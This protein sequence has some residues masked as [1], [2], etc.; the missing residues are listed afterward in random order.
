MTTA[1][2]HYRVIRTELT[3]LA[4]TLSAEQAATAVPALPGWSVHDTYAHVAG[5]CHDIVAGTVG[6]VNNTEWTA[7]HVAAGR[8]RTLAEICEQWSAEGPQAEA[9]LDDPAG[10]GN[11]RAVFDVFH[12]AHDIRGAL[13]RVEARQ[14][15]EAAFVAT[16]MTKFF[17]SGWGP[18]G[19]PAIRLST[20]S[21]SWHLGAEDAQ[22]VAALDTSDFE[23]ARM[24]IGRRSRAQMLAAGWEGD[25]EPVVDH[26]TVFGP[27]V[28][29]LTE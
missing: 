8:G 10:R 18:S 5:V 19:L 15:P 6:D 22:P 28:T 21:G 27:P 12:H 2:Q 9:F 4:A 17:R 24:L 14:T 7:G 1:G 23:L 20:P 25:P 29:D 13:G 11:V 26:L 16:L 3:D